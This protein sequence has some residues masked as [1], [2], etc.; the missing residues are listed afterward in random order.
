M[1]LNL[2]SRAEKKITT[3]KKKKILTKSGMAGK[4]EIISG[5]GHKARSFYVRGQCGLRSAR[6]RPAA[7]S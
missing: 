6:T 3:K 2:Y 5:R 4:Q 1:Q 7:P